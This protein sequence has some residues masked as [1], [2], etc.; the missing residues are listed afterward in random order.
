MSS[1]SVTVVLAAGASTRMKSSR[2]KLLHEVLGR[3]IVHWALDQALWA[4]EKVVF[5]VGHQREDVMA[6]LEPALATTTIRF[7][8]QSEQKGTGH[9]VQCALSEI[10]DLLPTGGNVFIMGGD[11]FLL[12]HQ[13]LE[14]FRRAH[15]SSKAALSLMTYNLAFPGAY[16]RIIRNADGMIESIVEAKDASSEQLAIKEVNA[17]F[18]FVRSDILKAALASLSNSNKAQEFYLTDLVSFC[19]KQGHFVTTFEIPFEEGLGINTQKELSEVAHVLRRRVNA[20]W[21][22][23]GVSMIDPSSIWVDADVQLSADV[24]L[25]PGVILKGKTR[26]HPR[27]RVGA[28]SVI[29]GAEL[30]EDVVIQ[31]FC[32]LKDS[33]VGAESDLGPYA[34]LR[35]GSVLDRKVHIGNFVE[36]KKS[37][38]K[39]GVKA[40]HLSYLGDSDIGRGTNIG[41]GT[42]TCNYDGIAKHQT[43]IGEDVFIGSNTSLVAPIKIGSGAIIGAGSVLTKEVSSNAIAVERSDQREIPQGASRFRERRRKKD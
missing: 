11:A 35:P 29:E 30:Y 41:A 5:V 19:R 42:I 33:V 4:A 16:G 36:V 18:Y 15:L 27:V 6:A 28:Y 9:A 31:P 14:N 21:M 7:A 2:S 22:A 23:Q 20:W 1:D 24:V 32:H 40:G 12:Q 13:T 3:P 34:R 25:E 17:G 10:D 38:L 37:H 39:E 26:I 8:V 43:N